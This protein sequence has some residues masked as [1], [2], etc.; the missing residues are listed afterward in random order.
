MR[1]K[2]LPAK[3]RWLAFAL[4]QGVL[5]CLIF[6][7]YYT[8]IAIVNLESMLEFPATAAKAKSLIKRAFKASPF[9]QAAK[10]AAILSVA[11]S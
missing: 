6:D 9:Q 7:P 5:F 3:R 11:R 1:L 8:T 4:S 10:S 2:D